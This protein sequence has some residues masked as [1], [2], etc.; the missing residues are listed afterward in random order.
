MNELVLKQ[1][2]YELPTVN[3]DLSEIIEETKRIQKMYGSMV[4]FE[5]DLPNMKKEMA[6]L[7]K[8]SKALNERKIA[9]AKEIKAPITQFE[10]EVGGIV[11]DIDGVYRWLKDQVDGFAELKKK[12]KKEAIL[13]LEEYVHEYMVF[14]DEWLKTNYS[15]EKVKADIAKQKYDFQNH[16]TM[17]ETTCKALN[18]ETEKYFKMLMNRVEIGEIISMIQN[19]KEVIEANL[20][21]S[22]E[23][24]QP[25]V[26]EQK[27]AEVLEDIQD[28]E[29]Y[30]FR[31]KISGTRSQLKA[32]R[33]F[34]TSN[35][36]TYEKE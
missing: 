12:E 1:I 20:A 16:C 3:Y 4:L 6:Q 15:I 24:P 29:L 21:K 26:E 23:T 9:I 5:E 30:T 28:T 13:A 11:K 35:G 27:L 32:L 10:S 14:D 34:I 2:T 7:N 17:I 36:M 18:L 19:D 31:L 22:A 8:I 25:R 33:E